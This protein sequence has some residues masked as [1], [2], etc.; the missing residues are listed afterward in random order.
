LDVRKRAPF[1]KNAYATFFLVLFA[2]YVP[3]YINCVPIVILEPQVQ[4]S[5]VTSKLIKLF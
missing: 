4:E 2:E 5:Q 1:A 3:I